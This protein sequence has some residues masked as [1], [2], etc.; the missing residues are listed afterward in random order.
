M[1]KSINKKIMT[2]KIGARERGPRLYITPHITAAS[3]N[4][5]PHITAASHNITPH[6][7]AASHN[8]TPHITAASHELSMTLSPNK[9]TSLT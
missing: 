7:T 6:I 3:H 9:A 1:F 2:Q 8:I 5:T 4:I